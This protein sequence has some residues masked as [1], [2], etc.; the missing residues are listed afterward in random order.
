MRWTGCHSDAKRAARGR[1]ARGS[2]C[3]WPVSDE[4]QIL[5]A[6]LAA[7]GWMAFALDNHSLENAATY[8]VIRGLERVEVKIDGASIERLRMRDAARFVCVRIARAVM[9]YEETQR[10]PR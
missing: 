9:D 10:L 7:R 3:W 4:E 6:W 8:A 5:A 2:R 1:D